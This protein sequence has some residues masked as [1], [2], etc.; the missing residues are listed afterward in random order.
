[1]TNFSYTPGMEG[2]KVGTTHG[3]DPLNYRAVS[4]DD[5]LEAHKRYMKALS[6]T[7]PKGHA[8]WC[9]MQNP[10]GWR[11][12]SAGSTPMAATGCNCAKS[13]AAKLARRRELR[14]LMASIGRKV[15]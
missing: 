1:M 15:A 14:D 4:A 3:A 7:P 11:H 2:A 5:V 13:A 9:Q 12:R 10:P 8:S 6:W